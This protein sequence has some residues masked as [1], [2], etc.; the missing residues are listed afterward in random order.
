MTGKNLVLKLNYGANTIYIFGGAS[1][2][3]RIRVK[4]GI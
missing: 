4:V 3:G 1:L 2:V